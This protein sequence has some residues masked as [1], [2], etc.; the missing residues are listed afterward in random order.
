MVDFLK[1]AITKGQD[2]VESDD[3]AK[4][5]APVIAQETKAINLIK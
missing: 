3:Y 2:E 5:P 1:W 4:L